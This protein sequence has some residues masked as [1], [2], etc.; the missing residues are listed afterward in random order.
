MNC[1]FLVVV[2]DQWDA[3]VLYST[4]SQC[5]WHGVIT[6]SDYV[7]II[8]ALPI[9]PLMRPSLSISACSPVWKEASLLPYTELVSH[10][11]KNNT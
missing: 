3:P 5:Q 4:C 10:Y 1:H 8:D 2:R 11:Y 7:G 9:V 6:A